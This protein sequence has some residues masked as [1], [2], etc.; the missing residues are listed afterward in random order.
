MAK[1][2]KGFLFWAGLVCLGVHT[3]RHTH[4]HQRR[5]V[6][7]NRT[8]QILTVTLQRFPLV[9]LH[10]HL[11][12]DDDSETLGDVTGNRGKSCGGSDPLG[13]VVLGDGCK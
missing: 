11:Q 10:H 8:K 5:K 7:N 6:F 13:V 9:L 3:G 12:E 1:R 4:I 2:C